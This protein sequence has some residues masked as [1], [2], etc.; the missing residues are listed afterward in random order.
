M[1]THASPVRDS[2]SLSASVTAAA[3]SAP[4]LLEP[5]LC[6]EMMSRLIQSSQGQQWRRQVTVGGV[7]N[8]TV[9]QKRRQTAMRL[10]AA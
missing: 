10:Y 7:K 6:S 4:M 2:L 3:P 5:R 8:E 9:F 1:W